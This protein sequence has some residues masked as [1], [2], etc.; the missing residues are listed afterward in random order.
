MPSIL[1]WYFSKMCF[2]S[3]NEVVERRMELFK[4][5]DGDAFFS[6]REWP[7]SFRRDFWRKPIGDEGSFKLMLFLIGNGLEPKLASEW[8]MLSQYWT[9]DQEKM[10]KRARQVDFVVANLEAKKN[11]WFYFDIIHQRLVYLNGTFK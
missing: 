11:V 6:M 3:F 10:K 7:A 9:Q 4:V 5:I 2:L 8:V 1:E